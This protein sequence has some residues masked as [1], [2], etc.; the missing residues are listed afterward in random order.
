MSPMSQGQ[1][2]YSDSAARLLRFLGYKSLPSYG[3]VV[4]HYLN[5]TKRTHLK[6]SRD[7]LASHEFPE[8]NSPRVSHVIFIWKRLKIFENVWK[9]FSKSR[10]FFLAV[11]LKTGKMYPKAEKFCS[12]E[13]PHSAHQWHHRL[14]GDSTSLTETSCSELHRER[15]R[16]RRGGH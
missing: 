7:Q 5:D 3:A 4:Q 16:K 2:S 10:C 8:K 1:K 13:T 14:S 15:E 12:T 9:R 11:S 6:I